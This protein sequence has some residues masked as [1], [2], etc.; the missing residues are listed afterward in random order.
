MKIKALTSGFGIGAIILIAAAIISLPLRTTQYFTVLEGA[1]G[2]Y[3]VVDWSAY[4]LFAVLAVAIVGFMALGIM[5][6]KSLDYSLETKKRPGF[7]ILAAVA[8]IGFIIDAVICYCAV[9]KPELNLGIS[10]MVYE[11]NPT[12]TY[13]LTAQAVAALVSALNFVTVAVGSLSGKSNGS[14]FKIISLA[15][16]L[17]SIFRLV[18]RFTRTIS[19]IRVSDLFF[20]MIMLIFM[21]LFFMAFAQVNA[22]IDSKN[23]EWKIAA[24]GLSAALLALVCFV[25]RFIVTAGG[26]TDLLYTYSSAEYCDI[27]V[28]LFAIA[29]VFTRITD[30]KE[31]PETV[32]ETD[33]ST[34]S[35]A[36]EE[37]E[38][39]T[40]KE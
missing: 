16:V 13:I 25:P 20:E 10:T 26:H 5:K 23:A 19:Y 22:K 39:D 21:M 12:T 9:Y 32:T 14:E 33:E 3:T 1:T 18:F 6:R 36:S 38:T 37:S 31:F 34:E 7:G 24:Y 29:A 11:Q 40:D 28:A 35:E 15:P 27:G 4:L 17:W 2:F 8:A 30:R